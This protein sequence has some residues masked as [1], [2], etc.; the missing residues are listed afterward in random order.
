MPY[1]ILYFIDQHDLAN[2]EEM[3][4]IQNAISALHG[5]NNVARKEAN[6]F[7]QKFQKAVCYQ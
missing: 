5:T 6:I 3:N 4:E 7:L 1:F 2:K